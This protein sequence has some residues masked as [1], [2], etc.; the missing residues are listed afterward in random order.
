MRLL[1][2]TAA[3]DGQRGDGSALDTS[4]QQQQQQGGGSGAPAR[5]QDWRSLNREGSAGAASAAAAAAAA[6]G[7]KSGGGLTTLKAI[8]KLKRAITPYYLQVR[9]QLIGH[10]R[11]TM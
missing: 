2:E 4:Q 10:A 3:A 5:G 6:L 1:S 7:A 11:N 9:V 8:T